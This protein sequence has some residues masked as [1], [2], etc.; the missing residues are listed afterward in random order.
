MNSI[1][2]ALVTA[3]AESTDANT[4]FPAV[5]LLLEEEDCLTSTSVTESV[6]ITD[7]VPSNV[8]KRTLD[9]VDDDGG[10]AYVEDTYASK[11]AS[12]RA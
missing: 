6:A 10:L 3:T 9:E 11:D 5:A 7:V 12:P 1:T 4:V 2:A 8:R